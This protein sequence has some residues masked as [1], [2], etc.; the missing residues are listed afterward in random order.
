[1]PAYYRVAISGVTAAAPADGF[2]DNKRIETYMAE[3]STPTTAAQTQAKE[4]ANLRYRNLI[5]NL[6]RLGNLYISNI[7]A[8]GAS[9]TAQ[10]TSFEFTVLSERGED[11]LV[12]EV[13]PG[14]VLTGADAIERMVA[15]SL[16]TSF[17]RSSDY[18]DPTTSTAPGNATA[19]ARIGN[20]IETLTV[21]ALAADITT[22][23]GL[24]TVTSIATV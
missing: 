9:A 1:M 24:V 3:G 22:A 21:G 5:D 17:T 2:I 6:Q 23:N 13:S 8:P 18:Y 20:R 4:R 15:I 12:F 19:Y 16:T 10:P 7:S 11:N 14:T